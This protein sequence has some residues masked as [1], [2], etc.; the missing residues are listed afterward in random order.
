MRMLARRQRIRFQRKARRQNQR[1][2]LSLFLSCVQGKYG[3]EIGGPSDVFRSENL[4]IYRMIGRLDNC[5]FS[6]SNVWANHQEA[7]L[8]HEAKPPGKSMFL[9]GSA[10]L[11]VP[12]ATYDVLLSSHNLEHIANPVKALREWQRVAKPGGVLVLVLPYCRATFDHRRNPT[13]VA[14][15]LQDFERGTGEDD[16]THLPEILA[17]HDLRF[18]PAAGTPEQFRARSLNNFSNR[19]LHHHVFDEHNSRE[20]LTHLGFSVLCV[21]FVPPMHMCLLAR[22]AGD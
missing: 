13:P 5:D 7:F 21:H 9:E 16:L 8:F 4:P 3:L 18:D 20:L 22:M 14:H 12:D 11:G 10:L 6:K 2:H 19:C 17:Q 1:N 15:M